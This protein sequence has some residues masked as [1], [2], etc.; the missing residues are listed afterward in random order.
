MNEQTTFFGVILRQFFDR[1]QNVVYR[2]VPVCKFF[3]FSV[4]NYFN[5]T[6][7]IDWAKENLPYW[8]DEVDR[9]S[10]PELY[11][12]TDEPYVHDPRPGGVIVMRGGFGDIASL[13]LPEERYF[14]VCPNQAEVDLIKL[15]RPDLQ[16]NAITDYYRDNPQAVAELTGQITRILS[17][18]KDDPLWGSPGLLEWFKGEIPAIVRML[19]AVHSLFQMLPVSAV[20]TISSTYSMDGAL[21]LVARANR[22]ASFTLQHGLLAEHEL[23]CHLPVLAT[24]KLVWGQADRSWYQKYGFPESRVAVV[25]SPRFDVIFNRKWMGGAELRRLLGAGPSQTIIVYAAQILRFNQIIAPIVFEGL[26]SNPD[27]FLVMLLHPGEDPALYE[28]MAEGFTHCKIVRFGHIG[29]YD[30]L[31]GADLFLTYYSTAALE[32]MLFKLPVV[33]VE[34]MPPTFSFGDRGASIKVTNGAELGQ[35]VKRLMT[36]AAFRQNA[37]DRYR[38]FLPGYCLP[39]GCAG[40]RLFEQVESLSRSGGIA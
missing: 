34:P 17:G 40:S 21:N 24:Q 26:K 27:L 8:R 37:I 12:W 4:L 14:L 39:D 6:V 11:Q 33:T 31:S 16:A 22:V 36:D 38:D 18:L 7:G 1:F 19:D 5:A 13:Y 35:V 15:N 25:G 28:P 10:E 32:A 20:V 30:A 9:L 3:Y 2:G 29:I 23:F